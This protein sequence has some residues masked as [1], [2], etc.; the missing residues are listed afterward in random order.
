MLLT[1]YEAEHERAEYERRIQAYLLERSLL[2]PKKKRPN[3]IT[4]LVSQCI[5]LIVNSG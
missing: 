3:L 4:Y 1:L 5:R 2:E